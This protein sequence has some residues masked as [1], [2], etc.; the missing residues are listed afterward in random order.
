VDDGFTLRL[1]LTI[2]NAL[3]RS[4]GLLSNYESETLDAALRAE[5]QATD[6]EKRAEILKT[7]TLPALMEEL[8][9]FP[10]FTSMFII[11]VNKRVENLQVGG[12]GALH[13]HEVSLATE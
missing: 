4:P 7:V 12:T 2:L 6:L 9:E 3:F 1:S 10:L 13:L 5:S 8:P 11:G